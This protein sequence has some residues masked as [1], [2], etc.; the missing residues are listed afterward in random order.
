[1]S[2]FEKTIEEIMNELPPPIHYDGADFVAMPEYSP[3]CEGCAFEDLP[4]DSKGECIQNK[5]FEKEHGLRRCGTHGI[6]YIHNDER[7]VIEYFTAKTLR[8][9]GVKHKPT[10]PTNLE[11]EDATT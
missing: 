1:M 4:A 8:R 9:M 2:D 7:A 11:D 5:Y 10:I 6:I 3:T